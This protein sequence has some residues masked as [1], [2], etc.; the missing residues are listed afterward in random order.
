MDDYL[1]RARGVADSVK[2]AEDRKQLLDDLAT[3]KI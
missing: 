3:I 1:D 2:K